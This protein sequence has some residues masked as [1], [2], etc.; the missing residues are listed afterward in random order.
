ML[1]FFD[2]RVYMAIVLDSKNHINP[3]GI[4]TLEDVLEELLQEEIMDEEDLRKELEKK[5]ISRDIKIARAFHRKY[6]SNHSIISYC[7][8]VRQ[9]VA[10]PEQCLVLIVHF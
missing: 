3:T 1:V 4:I 8:V 5:E 10:L 7:E 6:P 2:S 9:I